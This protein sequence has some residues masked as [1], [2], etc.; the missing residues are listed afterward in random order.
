[1][2][3]FG[4]RTHA[5]T[6]AHGFNFCF[7]SILEPT[8]IF[9]LLYTVLKISSISYPYQCLFAFGAKRNGTGKNS[10]EKIYFRVRTLKLEVSLCYHRALNHSFFPFKKFLTSSSYGYYI[11]LVWPGSLLI[12]HHYSVPRL[13][14]CIM[15]ENG[16][17][18]EFL[19]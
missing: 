7:R 3:N 5:R 6:H 1:M 4:A 10:S 9:S 12:G 11:W 2:Y 13:T 8:C 17:P 19:V 15:L 18:G 16:W 14:L